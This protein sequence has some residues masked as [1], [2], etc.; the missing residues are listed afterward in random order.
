MQTPNMLLTPPPEA[1]IGQPEE[2]L[3]KTGATDSWGEAVDHIE[4]DEGEHI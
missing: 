2:T 1:W 4:G 3:A